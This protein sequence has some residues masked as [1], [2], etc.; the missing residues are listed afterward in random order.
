[1]AAGEN[2]GSGAGV[3]P[4]K[5]GSALVAS[6]AVAGPDAGDAAGAA[7]PADG[8]LDLAALLL[9]GRN[10][11]LRRIAMDANPA[12]TVASMPPAMRQQLKEVRVGGKVGWGGA[13]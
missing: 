6:L 13:S 7:V 3:G 2:V 9:D 10:A 8:G 12:K 1:M 4:G 5:G 11:P